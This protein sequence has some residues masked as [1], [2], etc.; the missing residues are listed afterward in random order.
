LKQVGL[1]QVATRI[2]QA[3]KPAARGPR[4]QR[5]KQVPAPQPL[6][7][8]EQQP[9]SQPVESYRATQRPQQ[10]ARAT[11]PAQLR[12][13][14]S[15]A[16]TAIANQGATSILQ[17]P[18]GFYTVQLIALQDESKILAYA[19]DNGLKYPLYAQI[20]SQGRTLYVLLLGLYPDRL[21]AARAKD[22][23]AA[24]RHLSAKPWIRELGPL[25]DAI[26]LA[27]R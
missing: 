19:R 8:A 20:H 17:Q 4:H 18:A 7:S 2:P 21:L 1:K 3:N 15:P 10:V 23:W 13:R 26:R 27:V 16:A 25:Q 6:E 5:A 9:V 14:P 22:E 12:G 24:A 11:P